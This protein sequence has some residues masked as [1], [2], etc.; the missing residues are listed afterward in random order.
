MTKRKFLG[1]TNRRGFNK[2]FVLNTLFLNQDFQEIFPFSTHHLPNRKPPFLSSLEIMRAAEWGFESGFT[3]FSGLTITSLTRV[4]RLILNGA[5]IS[6]HLADAL[7]IGEKKVKK[8]T[9]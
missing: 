8:Y 6:K 3:G 7:R 5:F 2:P 1:C 9:I 4:G